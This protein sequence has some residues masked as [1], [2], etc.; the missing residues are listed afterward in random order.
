M[1]G[2]IESKYIK[3]VVGFLEWYMAACRSESFTRQELDEVD[4][5]AKT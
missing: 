2:H 5:H 1:V 3:C 4:S